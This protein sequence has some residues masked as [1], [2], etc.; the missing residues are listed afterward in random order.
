MITYTLEITTEGWP[1]R[2]THELD[3]FRTRQEAKAAGRRIL[4]SLAKD[5]SDRVRTTATIYEVRSTSNP[6][7]Y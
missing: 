6:W 5:A 3:G 2:T 4:D 7:A 1:R